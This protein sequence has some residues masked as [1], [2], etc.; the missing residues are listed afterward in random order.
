MCSVLSATLV[1]EDEDSDE[2]EES[3]DKPASEAAAAAS[4]A[5]GITFGGQPSSYDF[6]GERKPPA[7]F[8]Q[9]MVE[10]FKRSRDGEPRVALVHLGKFKVSTKTTIK[11]TAPANPNDAWGGGGGW[12]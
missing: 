1:D 12:G 8:T 10:A 4:G 5:A 7:P 9:E 2:E 11:A 6:I 3:K